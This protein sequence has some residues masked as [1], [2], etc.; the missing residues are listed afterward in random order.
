[1]WIARNQ[2]GTLYLFDT[3]PIRDDSRFINVDGFLSTPLD[4]VLNL[5]RGFSEVTWENS[6]L[7]ITLEQ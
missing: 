7:K 4:H 6:P 1:M 5:C 3:K 2:N